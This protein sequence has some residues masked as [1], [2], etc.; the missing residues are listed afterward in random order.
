MA[1]INTFNSNDFIDTTNPDTI[2]NYLT[3]IERL[4]TEA[5]EDG[6]ITKFALIR[7]DDFFPSNY[8]WELSCANTIITKPKSSFSYE[9]RIAMATCEVSPKRNLPF[10]IPSDENE[11]LEAL[12][13]INPDTGKIFMP[14]HFRSTK[15]F[16]INT[17][18]EYT[19]NY[20]QVS[21]NRN[22]VVIDKIDNFINSG[23]AYSLAYHDAYL[24]V[25]H[26]PLPISNNA[27]ILINYE[28]Y[29][30]MQNDAT[31]KQLLSQRRV[32]LYKGD[33]ALAINIVL[34]KL[35]ILPSRAGV[36]VEY[37][38]ATSQILKD[39]IINL[40]SRSNIAYDLNHGNINGKG[41]HFSDLFD[42]MNNEYQIAQNNFI[43]FLKTKFPDFASKLS[44]YAFSN[45]VLDDIIE[46]YGTNYV[47]SV[48]DQYNQIYESQFLIRN[49]HYKQDRQTITPEISELF[50]ATLKLVINLFGSEEVS[51]ELMD[52]LKNFFHGNTVDMQV[53]AALQIQKLTAN[54]KLH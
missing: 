4:I 48:I 28:K 14:G 40:A 2:N 27:I 41:G 5:K 43:T 31:L 19:G 9:L 1:N 46:K 15:H 8:Y 26:E 36:G 25:T 24:D 17:P 32:I 20:N 30:E 29:K 16:T 38:N 18:L 34:A 51:P 45:G 54:L 3:T 23:Y 49:M 44:Y 21:M 39:S 6:K 37:D 13:K 7:E 22:F 50:K 10:R 33:V 11:I 35:G 47:L 53:K 12:K 42:T 52:T